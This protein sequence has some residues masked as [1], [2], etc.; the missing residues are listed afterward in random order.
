KSPG[1][2]CQLISLS[3]QDDL[4]CSS[5]ERGDPRNDPVVVRLRRGDASSAPALPSVDQAVPELSQGVRELGNPS[6]LEILGCP[7]V[8]DDGLKLEPSLKLNRCREV[9]EVSLD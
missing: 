4:H 1:A 2:A 9:L 7:S 8:L 6:R 5:G 3:E